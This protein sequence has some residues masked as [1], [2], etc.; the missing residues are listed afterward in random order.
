MA[1]NRKNARRKPRLPEPRGRRGHRAVDEDPKLRAWLTEAL[2]RRPAPTL[3][4]LV[5]EAKSTGFAIGRSAIWGF[6]VA[7]TAEQER[8]RLMLELAQEYNN[9]SVEGNVLD[10]E[11]AV[12]TLAT[13]RIYQRL[14]EK[15]DLDADAL[16]LLDVFRKLQSSSSQRERTRFAVERGIRATTIRIRAQMQEILKKDPD[17]LRRVLAAIDQAAT[18]VRE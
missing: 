3:D 9:A 16:E 18:E 10:V 15:A 14:L 8:K 12:S 13:S 7:F 17:T 2:Q 6:R 11:T 1:T 5:E 4:E